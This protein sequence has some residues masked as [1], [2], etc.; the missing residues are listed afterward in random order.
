MYCVCNFF[1]LI[2]GAFC[3]QISQMTTHDHNLDYAAYEDSFAKEKPDKIGTYLT[4]LMT[5]GS[6]KAKRSAKALQMGRLNDGIGL[7]STIEAL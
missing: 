3:G 1:P 5:F 6:L 2:F 7:E 4:V